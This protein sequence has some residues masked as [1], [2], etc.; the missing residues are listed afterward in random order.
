MNVGDMYGNDKP[1]DEESTTQPKS[2]ASFQG[3]NPSDFR[4]RMQT[5][6][7][8][9]ATKGAGESPAQPTAGGASP[10]DAERGSAAPAAKQPT[11]VRRLSALIR[12]SS[13]TDAGMA[14]GGR[15]AVSADCSKG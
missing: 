10:G 4:S 11:A 12:S 8:V 9:V 14:I 3:S 6:R 2:I 15:A 5:L 1:V 7:T 13:S